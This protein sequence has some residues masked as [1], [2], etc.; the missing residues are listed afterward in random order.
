MPEDEVQAPEQ[1][2]ER[3]EKTKEEPKPRPTRSATIAVRVV[4]EAGKST[5][6]Q[7]LDEGG[8][9]HK[10]TVPA[11]AIVEGNVKASTLKAG[12]DPFRWEQEGLDEIWARGL[13]RAGIY[14]VDDYLARSSRALSTLTGIAN[15][16]M[17]EIIRRRK[18]Q[19]S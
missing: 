2:V 6:V 15:R 14:T 19:R 8:D 17:K 7:W 9:Y 13:R 12:E 1:E 18:S 10:A 11:D 4:E 3:P 16:A 5:V